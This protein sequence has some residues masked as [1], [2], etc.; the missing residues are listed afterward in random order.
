[1]RKLFYT[2]G[3]ILSLSIYGCGG[4][5]QPSAQESTQPITSIEQKEDANED[6]ITDKSTKKSIL[7]I[8]EDLN[9]AE[10]E[11][12]IE[13]NMAE[14]RDTIVGRFNGRVIDTLIC[15]PVDTISQSEDFPYGGY[16][17]KWRVYTTKGS[18]KD[19]FIGYTIGIDLVYEGDLDGNGT[20]EWGFVTQWPTS[21]W[22]RYNIFTAKNKEWEYLIEPTSIF[23]GDIDIT[24]SGTITSDEIAQRSKKKGFVSIKFSDIR[25]GEFLLIDTLIQVNSWN[26]QKQE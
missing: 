15:E 13:E 23:L 22:M 19:L 2:I 11:L 4:G 12:I 7:I 6:T 10:E 14:Y 5:K 9:F 17:Y 25:D 26:M 21:N 16:H 1:M 24:N 8:R 18:V 20:E 3:I